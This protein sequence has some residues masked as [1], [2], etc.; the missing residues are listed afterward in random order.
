MKGRS[1]GYQKS[2]ITVGNWRNLMVHLRCL[3]QGMHRSSSSNGYPE[4]EEHW[5]RQSIID[6]LNMK[7]SGEPLDYL[8]ECSGRQGLAP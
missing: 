1:F 8:P 7:E 4:Q 3:Q 6:L 5:S 2:S